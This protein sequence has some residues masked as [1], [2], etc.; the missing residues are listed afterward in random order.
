MDTFASAAA[1][2]IGAFLPY[3]LLI[4]ATAQQIVAAGA[5]H[6]VVYF[7]KSPLECPIVSLP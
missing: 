3:I 2:A 1:V 5:A 6:V 7:R 4:H